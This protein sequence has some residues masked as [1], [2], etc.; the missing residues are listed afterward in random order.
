MGRCKF[1]PKNTMSEEIRDIKESISFLA[2]TQRILSESILLQQQQFNEFQQVL[3]NSLQ[4]SERRFNASQQEFERR[5]NASQERLEAILL[6]QQR[7]IQ[8]SE[9]RVTSTI[10]RQEESDLRFNILLQEI[11]HTNQRIDR[12]EQ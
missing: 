5:F 3:N 1:T 10:E 11:R 2:E 12:I 8:I 6:N 9:D 4:E 7:Q